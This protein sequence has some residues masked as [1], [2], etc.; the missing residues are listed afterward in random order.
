MPGQLESERDVVSS[1]RNLATAE[2]AISRV[3]ESNASRIRDWAQSNPRRLLILHQ[4][5]GYK[6]GYGVVRATGE[7]KY[8]STVRVAIKFEKHNGMPYY[9]L[10]SYL[11]K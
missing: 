10:T 3:M 9:V 4:D 8:T 7:F 1:F 2:W 11:L 6:A 5:V